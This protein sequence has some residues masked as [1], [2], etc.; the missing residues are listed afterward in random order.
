MRK[1]MVVGLVGVLFLAG[2]LG[3]A[4]E[5]RSGG[6]ENDGPYRVV[7][8]PFNVTKKA[9]SAWFE[10]RDLNAALNEVNAE[11][12]VLAG[13]AIFEQGGQPHALFVLR[14]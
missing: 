10:D 3:A 14:K 9:G 6:N 8:R 7:V 11:G 2:V 5:S 12:F 4:V 1:R 13:S